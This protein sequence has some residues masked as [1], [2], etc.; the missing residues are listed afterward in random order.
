MVPAFGLLV[1]SSNLSD[2]VSPS[3]Y[4]G[5]SPSVRRVPR[6]G[7][8]RPGRPGRLRP[9]PVGGPVG[10]AMSEVAGGPAA[11]R[12]SPLGVP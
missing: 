7:H 11:G 2:N 12:P 6:H 4:P 5:N 9:L 8:H 1:D 3:E 10:G